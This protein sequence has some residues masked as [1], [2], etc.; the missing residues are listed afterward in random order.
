MSDRPTGVAPVLNL[1]T[2]KPERLFIT[3]DGVGAW[4]KDAGEY[5]LEERLELRQALRIQQAFNQAEPDSLDDH[6][7][8]AYR[9]ALRQVGQIAVV[10][11]DEL[12]SKL[13]DD[14]LDMIAGYLVARFFKRAR[15]AGLDEI[16][17]DEE[18]VEVRTQKQARS[19]L[20]KARGALGPM[21]R[22]VRGKASTT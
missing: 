22:P 11:D 5:S 10:A 21:V 4:L 6:D 19:I 9:A 8:A 18:G 16:R 15:A 17:D 7:T 3:I 13:N 12:K 14:N 1:E 20:D 2:M